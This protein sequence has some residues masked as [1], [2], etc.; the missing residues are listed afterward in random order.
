VV[1]DWRE[2]DGMERQRTEL[3]TRRD[4]TARRATPER[5]DTALVARYER[6]LAALERSAVSRERTGLA[7]RLGRN[8]LNRPTRT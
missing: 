7:T 6:L 4:R 5:D 8:R 3:S 1:F 2:E